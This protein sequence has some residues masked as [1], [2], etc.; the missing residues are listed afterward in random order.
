M[1]CFLLVHVCVCVRACVNVQTCRAK[2]I[3]LEGIRTSLLSFSYQADSKL[4][5]REVHISNLKL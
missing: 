1:F 4:R 3:P 2:P 5:E